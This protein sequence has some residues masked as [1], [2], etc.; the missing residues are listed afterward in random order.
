[1]QEFNQEYVGEE[2]PFEGGGGDEETPSSKSNGSKSETSDAEEGGGGAGKR[3][4]YCNP[5]NNLV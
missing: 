5:R 2:G 1:M 3:D 4:T